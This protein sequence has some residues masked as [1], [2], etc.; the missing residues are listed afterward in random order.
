[1]GRGLAQSSE[2]RRAGPRG[3]CVGAGDPRVPQALTRRDRRL[4]GSTARCPGPARRASVE[5]QAHPPQPASRASPQCQA[6]LPAT[7]A[8]SAARAR[9]PLCWT[10]SLPVSWCVVPGLLPVTGTSASM[11]PGERLLGATSGR[12]E[13]APSGLGVDRGAMWF[14]RASRARLSLGQQGLGEEAG[15][16][17]GTFTAAGE[18]VGLLRRQ[19]QEPPVLHL[20]LDVPD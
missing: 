16:P 10:A 6:R 7:P 5:G 2:G 8:S 19:P 20:S 15:E 13:S 12:S 14:P 18:A 4:T 11:H 17:Q 3:A 1:M 9:I